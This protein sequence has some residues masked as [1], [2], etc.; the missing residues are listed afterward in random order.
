MVRL[1]LFIFIPCFSLAQIS[2][3]VTDTQDQPISDVTI[4]ILSTS[5]AYKSTTDG[6]FLLNEDIPKSTNLYFSKEGYKSQT[7]NYSNDDSLMV[8]LSELHVNIDEVEISSINHKLS[9]NQTLNIQS[10]KIAQLNESSFNLV[11]SLSKITGVDQ[12]TTGNGIQKVVVRGL[13]GMRVVT[14]MNGTRIENQQWGSDHGIGFTDLGLDKVEL[15]K[16]PASII[17]GA[18]ALG[19]AIYFSDESFNNKPLQAMLTSNFESSSMFH[20]NQLALKWSLRGFKNNTYLEYGSA[21]D[22][23]LPNKTYLFNSRFS[24][25][26]FKTAFG[27][28]SKRWVMNL[29]YQYNQNTMGIPAHTHGADPTLGELTSTNRDVREPTRP[30]QFNSLHLLNIES[31]LYFNENT[32]KLILAN[33]NNRL[34]E[35]EAWTI[36]YI[37]VYLN[38]T[39]LSLVFTKPISKK[40]KWSIGSQSSFQMNLNQPKAI[41][42][43]IP[44]T[45]TKD[46]GFYSL[47]EYTSENQ[48]SSQLAVRGDNRTISLNDQTFSKQYNALSLSYGIAK[49]INAHHIRMSF[50]S[51]FRTPNFY[52]LLADGFHHASRR[53]EIGDNGLKI[54]KGNQF[55]LSYEWTDNH[56]EFII[57]PFYHLISDYIS[58]NPLDSVI[59]NAPV[60]VYEQYDNV[61]LKGVEMNLHFHPHFAHQLHF[62]LGL[63]LLEGKNLDGGFLALMPANNIKTIIRYLF[64]KTAKPLRLNTVFIEYAHY[65]Q[66]KN[67]A[68]NEETTDSYNLLDGGLSFSFNK[69]AIFDITLGVKNITNTT[70]VPH[71][72]NLKSFMIPNP[73]RSFFIKLI[74]NL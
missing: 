6:S 67:V 40:L 45:T 60:F 25:M 4:L 8:K 49:Q 15:V 22:Y 1:I 57:N 3:I 69:Q 11:E 24:Q 17:F 34:E 23:Q 10:R 41:S 63:S 28:N 61:H 52:E 21:G 65:I 54:E 26:A 16:G 70:Y 72:S 2:G 59:E 36:P 18:D 14:L 48:L 42:Q 27:Y 5:T 50:S 33:S 53:Y 30:T 9:A 19:G 71:L 32:L 66:Q 74:T 38:S 13:S 46:I 55:D 37:D 43:L 12:T 39:Q 31:S 62:D 58:L 47:L 64:D 44:N 56:L 29:R 68:I 51:A 73:G 7:V 35:F 20:N